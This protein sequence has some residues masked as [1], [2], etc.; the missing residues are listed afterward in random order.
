MKNRI[1]IF[2]ILFFSMN[3]MD[4]PLSE[5]ETV[6]VKM[7]DLHNKEQ[8]KFKK[9]DLNH[10]EK[11]LGIMREQFNYR[12]N[13]EKYLR[14]V[15]TLL[16]GLL[17]QHQA[18]R[19]LGDS[20]F[21]T[22]YHYQL[23]DKYQL[24]LNKLNA[25]TLIRPN[26]E[27]DLILTIPETS[28]QL[29]ILLAHYNLLNESKIYSPEELSIIF[30]WIFD[31]EK[32]AWLNNLGLLQKTAQELQLEENKIAEPRS[33]AEY[34][35]VTTSENLFSTTDLLLKDNFTY[36][37]E[38]IR[39]STILQ[40]L[41][42]TTL[43]TNAIEKA[44]RNYEQL[45]TDLSQLYRIHQNS[46][47]KLYDIVKKELSSVYRD[48]VLSGQKIPAIILLPIPEQ[49]RILN[50]IPSKFPENLEMIKNP[51]TYLTHASLDSEFEKA[52]IEWDKSHAIIKPK[53]KKKIRR[54]KQFI[55]EA[56]SPESKAEEETEV[57]ESIEEAKKIAEGPDG[58]YI[59]EGMEDDLKIIIEDPIHDSTA[60]IFK[61]KNSPLNTLKLKNL[62][63]VKYTTSVNEWFTD[64]KKARIDQG[65]L[66][67]KN[68][69]YRAGE[70]DW[71]P[72]VLHAFPKLVDEYI[73]KYGTVSETPSRRIK[74]KN[75]IIVTIP[76][77]MEYPDGNEETGIFTYIID[78]E[79]GQWFHRMFTPSSHKKMAA[80]FM[81][82]GYFAPEV[83]GYY[84]VYFPPLV[85]P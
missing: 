6:P 77:N 63:K 71:K 26:E 38:Y 20:A 61:T 69:R 11:F 81:E 67:P 78:P 76:G 54:K 25:K 22:N 41:E 34:S 4:A 56:K 52:R 29:N 82:K 42:T 64:P 70:P 46:Y 12:G 47:Q 84:D 75:D 8:R 27:K 60:T 48:A 40:K 50:H 13:K 18:M 7:Q 37:N 68:P 31:K 35:V 24:N 15:Q 3:G 73:G 62:P 66:D 49:S 19:Y 36:A 74:G 23:K 59:A 14:Q 55:Q 44:S 58:S 5:T 10:P 65:Y 85:K 72:I 2:I 21:F 53:M 43:D 80:D 17:A 79:N 51:A 83:K 1:S 33:K 45:M 32:G 9:Y 28:E 39:Q 16:S 30:S 57:I